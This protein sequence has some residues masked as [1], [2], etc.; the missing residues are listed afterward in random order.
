VTEKESATFV[1]EVSHDEV[2]AQWQKGD[3]KLKAGDNIKMRQEGEL[4]INSVPI[5]TDQ[6]LSNSLKTL[7]LS[8]RTYVLLFKSVKAEDAGEIKFTAEKASS[9]AKLKV[10]GS[11]SCVYRIRMHFAFS[12]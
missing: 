2:E 8:G 12:V 5:R 1:C 9:T 3:A 10:K 7:F 11:W 6:L 4:N